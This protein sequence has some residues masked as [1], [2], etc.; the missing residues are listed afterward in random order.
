M[1]LPDGPSRSTNKGQ[2]NVTDMVRDLL[3]NDPEFLK[4][5]E[6]RIAGRAVVKA[7]A[8][9]RNKV[10]LT[11]QQLAEHMGCGQSKLSKMESGVDAD[12]RLGDILA[13]LRAV[14]CSLKLSILPTQPASAALVV[15][16]LYQDTHDMGQR[17]KKR[18]PRQS[19]TRAG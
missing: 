7:L 8:I 16:M 1:R 12:L 18:S 19:K 14:G 4:E 10:G 17:T 2:S 15:E 11:Q 13:Y 5:L 3:A 9:T 6:G